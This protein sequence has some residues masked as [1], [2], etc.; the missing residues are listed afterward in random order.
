MTVHD[1]ANQVLRQYALGSVTEVSA[2]GNAGGF[3]GARFWR[4]TADGQQFCLRLWPTKGHA[5]DLAWIHQILL[6]SFQA[7]VPV[8]CPI[9]NRNGQTLVRFAG[10]SF[11]LS[12]W[13][14]G[15]AD[16]N[17]A[18][19]VERLR[20]MLEGLGN[21]H[22]VFQDSFQY[23]VSPAIKRRFSQIRTASEIVAKLSRGSAPGPTAA[24]SDLSRRLLPAVAGRLWGL[25][26]RFG[27]VVS[28]EFQLGPVIQ[29]VH[30]DHVLFSENRLTGIVDFGSMSIDSRCL[31][32]ARLIGSLE[33]DNAAP[34]ELA[35]DVY[36]QVVG[37]KPGGVVLSETET[38]LVR[39]LNECNQTLGVL[40]WLDWILLQNKQFEDWSAI[41]KRLYF[42][43]KSL[44][45]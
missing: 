35:L 36:S 30:H 3:S 16:F 34:W 17:S 14:P 32:L 18:A 41:E 37:Q 6:R 21:F 45:V 43:A 13:M 24:I 42:F 26:K 29:D 1:L 5:P 10:Q 44:G 4:V 11:E 38:K 31:D 25:E 12:P 2:L 15:T 23:G 20:S 40:N 22:Q 19:N 7:G 28:L 9:A 8:A 33:M 39:L 27:E